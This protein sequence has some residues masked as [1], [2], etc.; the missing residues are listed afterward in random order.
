MDLKAIDWDRVDR[1]ALEA[2]AV[3]DAEDEAAFWLSRAP[4]ERWAGVE[5]LRRTFHGD[6]AIDARLPRL[7]ELVELGAD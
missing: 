2:I 4:A 3:E 7:L 6:A 5:H 1:T